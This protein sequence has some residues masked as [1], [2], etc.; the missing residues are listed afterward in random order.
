MAQGP[1]W[2]TISA[3]ALSCFL[4]LLGR[5]LSSLDSPDTVLHDLEQLS[6]SPEQWEHHLHPAEQFLLSQLVEN[7]R[8]AVEKYRRT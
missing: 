6:E 5:S 3:E 2:T 8:V 1:N 4:D 7:I